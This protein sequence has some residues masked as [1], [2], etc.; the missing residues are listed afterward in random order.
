VLDK[1]ISDDD[2]LSFKVAKVEG[3]SIFCDW[4]DIDNQKNGGIDLKKLYDEDK[5]S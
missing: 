5:E 1:D 2:K 3:F 4:K